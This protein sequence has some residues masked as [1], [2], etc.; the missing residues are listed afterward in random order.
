MK[1]RQVRKQEKNSIRRIEAGSH[2]DV[3]IGG[4]RAWAR[5]SIQRYHVTES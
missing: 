3:H 2:T 4:Y 1:F 5:G